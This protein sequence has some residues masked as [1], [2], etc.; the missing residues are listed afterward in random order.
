MR[1]AEGAPV[2]GFAYVPAAVHFAPTQATPAR[3]LPREPVGFGLVTTVQPV[4]FQC[5]ISVAPGAVPLFQLPTAKQLVALTQET[6]LRRLNVHPAG[7]ATGTIVHVLP[8]HRSARL[9]PGLCSH[10]PTAMQDDG[11]VHDTPFSALLY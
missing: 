1:V 6:A 2:V 5:V 4:P 9:A 3:A 8:F 11:L 10:T 7:F